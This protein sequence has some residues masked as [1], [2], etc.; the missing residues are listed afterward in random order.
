MYRIIL[1]S[2]NYNKTNHYKSDVLINQS[3]KCQL[4]MHK[5]IKSIKQYNFEKFIKILN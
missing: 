3:P 4:F 5:S 1:I 2:D